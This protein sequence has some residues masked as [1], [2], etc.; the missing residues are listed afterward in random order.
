MATDIL[1][2]YFGSDIGVYQA[3]K[4]SGI[5]SSYPGTPLKVGSRGNDVK[6]IQNQLNT[7]NGNYP[8]IPKV[9]ADGIYGSRTAAS[10]KIFQEVFNLPQTGIVDFATWYKISQIYVAVTRLANP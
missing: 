7:I 4:V 5:P 3:A 10:V 1:K 9:I 8:G 2:Y 6:T